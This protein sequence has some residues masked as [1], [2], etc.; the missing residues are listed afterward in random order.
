M[1][2][3]LLLLLVTA[4]QA[5]L[6]VEARFQDQGR[7]VQLGRKIAAAVQAGNCIN[8][9]DASLGFGGREIG[10]LNGGGN[11]CGKLELADRVVAAAKKSCAGSETSRRLIIEAAMDLVAAEK[12]FNPFTSN[13]D[14]VCLEEGFPASEELKGIIQFVDPR[15]SGPNNR[16]AAVNARA[17]ALNQKAAD[18]LAAAKAAGNGPGNPDNLTMAELLEDN[19]FIDIQGFIP[20]ADSVAAG[21]AAAPTETDPPRA[22]VA[23]PPSL[24]A[25][26]PAASTGASG[27]GIA[28]AKSL[29]EQAITILNGI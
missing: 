25:A 21:N 10:L 6:F 5:T 13:K 27:N 2:V 26:T 17:S 22:N 28:Q 20:S 9:G 24:P 8:S 15:T 1:Q 16:D 4:L 14:Q 7:T 3:N 19:G 23:P 18:I 12:N 11:A 29:L